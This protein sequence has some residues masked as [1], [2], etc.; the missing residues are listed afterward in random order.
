MKKQTNLL[1]EVLGNYIPTRLD[2]RGRIYIPKKMRRKLCIKEGD[3]LYVIL[4]QDKLKI[5]TVSSIKKE[6]EAEG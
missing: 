5:L 2:D 3:I 1:E 6:I 4:E